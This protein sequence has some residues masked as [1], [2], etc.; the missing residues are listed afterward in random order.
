[1]TYYDDPFLAL[2]KQLGC[3]ITVMTP[4]KEDFAAPK[5]TPKTKP[6]VKKEEEIPFTDEEIDYTVYAPRPDLIQK[7]GRATI[8]HW[9]DGTITKVV[10][11]EGQPD[12]DFHAFTAAL[13]KR[14]YG[15]TDNVIQE[16][17]FARET[18]VEKGKKKRD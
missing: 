18:P 10:R 15:S 1:M 3:K 16:I 9:D 12:N 5:V 7:R 2:L 8:V 13:A 4:K 17:N 6:Q 11:E 14:V